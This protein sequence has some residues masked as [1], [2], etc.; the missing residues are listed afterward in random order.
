MLLGLAAFLAAPAG[1]AASASL[2]LRA[3]KEDS[4]GYHFAR[5]IAATLAASSQAPFV[6]RVEA[7]AGAAANATDAVARGGP[8]MFVSEP[9]WVAEAQKGKKA[10][11]IRALFPLPFL[12]LHWVVRADR[13]FKSFAALSGHRFVAG[14]PGSFTAE[15]TAAVLKLESPK[16]PIRTQPVDG[17]TAYAAVAADKASGFAEAAAFPA[18]DILALAKRVPLQLLSVRQDELAKLL[19]A[20]VGVTAMVIPRAIYPGMGADTVTVALPLGVYTTRAMGR[21][22][23]YRITKA[24]WR[25]KRALAARDPRWAAVAPEALA[26]LGAPLHPGALQYYAERGLASQEVK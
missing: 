17:A 5:E 10:G 25:E 13:G 15:E 11:A 19:A 7:S 23:A 9:G 4:L 20:S 26:A 2:V 6:L 21:D 14:G 24:F 12:S 1:F 8:A 18:P 16:K 22:E 3:G